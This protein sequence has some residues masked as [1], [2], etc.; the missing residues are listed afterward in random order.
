MLNLDY[1]VLVKPDKVIFRAKTLRPFVR[2]MRRFDYEKV[3]YEVGFLFEVW[4][5]KEQL[6]E[7]GLTY[8]IN[9]FLPE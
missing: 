1:E 8:I 7:C 6:E 5:R 2:L 3:K 9:G 4:V